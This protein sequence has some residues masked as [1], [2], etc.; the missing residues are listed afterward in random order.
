MFAPRVMFAVPLLFS[1]MS[2]FAFAQASVH[3]PAES[4]AQRFTALVFQ[5]PSPPAVLPFALQYLVAAWP[6]ASAN[7]AAITARAAIC[8]WDMKA[9]TNDRTSA[10]VSLSGAGTSLWMENPELFATAVAATGISGS[11]LGWFGCNGGK[12]KD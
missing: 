6:G 2:L 12:I 11:G 3:G 7:N 5:T 1:A 10:T 9:G 8:L 4:V